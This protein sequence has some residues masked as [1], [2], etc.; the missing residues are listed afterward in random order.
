MSNR[1][2]TAEPIEREQSCDLCLGK[3]FEVISRR[4]RRGNNLT[5]VVC[6]R[7]GLVSHLQI[8]TDEQLANYYGKS[9]RHD[10]HGEIAPSPRR[11]IRAWNTGQ[12]IFRRVHG[13]LR[14]GD[15]V[16]EVGAGIGCTVKAFELA[17]YD[18]SGIEPGE[19][20]HAFSQRRLHARVENRM[21]GEV[22]RCP[23]YDFVL[24]VHVIEHFHS[25]GRA[26]RHIH[27]I[28]APGGRLY[29]ACPNLGA[30]HAAPGN[31]FHF[32][33]VYNFTHRTLTML[34]RACGFRTVR[35]LSPDNDRD[36]MMVFERQDEGHLQIDP[37][38][39]PETMRAIT[40]YN[41]LSYHLRPRYWAQRG[42][43][44]IQ[45][46]SERVRSQRRLE[47]IVAL[48]DEHRR[49]AQVC[50]TSEGVEFSPDRRLAG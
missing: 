8:P 46:L 23:T 42:R 49:Q 28:L 34:G 37:E 18:A 17:G 47:R 38:G 5:T 26:L 24:L 15:R 27:D 41:V 9:Y 14:P 45:H 10:Y 44:V 13:F 43:T 32:A 19:G 3:L 20:F 21:L 1:G 22:P 50:S 35:R 6:A 16:F 7:C 36:L 29:V 48:C 4:D 11:V 30:P 2:L 40:R 33:H 12:A 39:Y 31:L 25:P